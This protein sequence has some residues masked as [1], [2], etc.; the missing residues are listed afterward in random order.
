MGITWNQTQ[1][2]EVQTKSCP[3]ILPESTYLPRN[4]SIFVTNCG[5]FLE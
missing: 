4:K 1:E 3:M 5:L 2:T